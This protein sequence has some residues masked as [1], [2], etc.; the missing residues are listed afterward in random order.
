[1]KKRRV[2]KFSPG[3]AALFLLLLYA[4]LVAGLVKRWPTSNNAQ[5]WWAGPLFLAVILFLAALLWFLS[6]RPLIYERLWKVP[7]TWYEA[8]FGVTILCTGFALFV[9]VTGY[10]PSKYHTHQVPTSAGLKFLYW[11]VAPLVVGSAAY[12]FDR[13]RTH[14]RRR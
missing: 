2:W 5:P 7:R 3:G 12:V 1:M 10:T 8:C 4:P 14:E 11:A 9:F 13:Y 6:L